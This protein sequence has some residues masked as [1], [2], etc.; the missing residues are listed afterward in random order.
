MFS[1]GRPR[2]DAGRQVRLV[3]EGGA[4]GDL[5]LELQR[6]VVEE[7]GAVG[8][9]EEALLGDLVRVLRLV[10][11]ELDQVHRAPALQVVDGEEEHGGGD[12]GQQDS[13][14]RRLHGSKLDRNQRVAFG[15]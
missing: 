4:V 9:L 1:L 6:L 15:V 11:R 10:A 2:L 8:H 14:R 12:E 7:A 13:R 5:G 3:A